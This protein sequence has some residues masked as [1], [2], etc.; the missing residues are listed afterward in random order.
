MVKN[1]P[2]PGMFAKIIGYPFNE[3][4]MGTGLVT[5]NLVF[6]EELFLVKKSNQ[7]IEIIIKDPDNESWKKRR[8]LFNPGFH[9][10]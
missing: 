5:G 10:K 8:A 2:K 9:R 6:K 7:S 1:Y 3:R 4:F